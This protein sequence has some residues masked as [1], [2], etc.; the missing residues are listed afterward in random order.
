MTL[1]TA[2]A[3]A[4]VLLVLALALVPARDPLREANRAL[5]TRGRRRR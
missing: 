2:A 3:L 5:S 4:L 1:P